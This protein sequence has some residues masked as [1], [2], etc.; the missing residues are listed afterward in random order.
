MTFSFLMQYNDSN[1]AWYA[2]FSLHASQVAS[3]SHANKNDKMTT[4]DDLLWFHLSRWLWG[5]WHDFAQPSPSSLL[6][7]SS[8]GQPYMQE[9]AIMFLSRSS[10][11]YLTTLPS[12]GK[13]SIVTTCCNIYQKTTISKCK[14]MCLH[15]RQPQYFWHVSD[16]YNKNQFVSKEVHQWNIRRS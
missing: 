2:G 7:G 6:M 15:L 4:H 12:T 16:L 14:C 1:H 11:M 3:I 5:T 9:K 13:Y 10:I 8:R